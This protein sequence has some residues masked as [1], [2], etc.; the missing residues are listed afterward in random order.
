MMLYFYK[1][2]N[3]Q[4]ITGSGYNIP[5]GFTEYEVNSQ[6]KE[7]SDAVKLREA[8][9]TQNASN[10]IAQE[11]LRQTDWYVIRK[12]E[13]GVE[14]PQDILNKRQASRDAIVKDET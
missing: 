5:D 6:P 10:L 13:T 7:L 9:Q 1:I 2:E 11:Y 3:D 14:I 12:Q 4:L 8:T